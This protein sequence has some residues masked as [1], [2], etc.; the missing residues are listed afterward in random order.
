MGLTFDA[1]VLEPQLSDVIDLAWAFP[2]TPIVLDHCGTPLGTASYAGKLPEHY[3]R[4]AQSITA[5]AQCRN[6]S[7]KLGGLAMAFCGMPDKRPRRR[8]RFR[9]TGGDV[10]TLYRSLHRRIRPA[11][12]DVRIQLPGRSLGRDLSRFVERVQT[13]GIGRVGR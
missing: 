10:E 9:T 7:V 1:W 5:L 13:A 12:R 3:D 4:W 2:D 6:V 11:S 8:G